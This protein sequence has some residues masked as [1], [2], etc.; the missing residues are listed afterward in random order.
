MILA[1]N[2]WKLQ[3]YSGGQLQLG[4]GTQVQAHNQRRFSV[5]WHSPTSQLREVIEILRH[6]W[7][8]VFQ[9]NDSSELD[10][11]GKFYSLELMTDMFNTG[12]IDNPQIPIHIAGVNEHNSR[13]AGELCDGL[14]L[15]PVSSPRYVK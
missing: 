9:A 3:Q 5:K 12:P 4:L 10:Y 2:A 6:I 8:D 7:E 14:C 1:Y 15:H 11:D 13:L